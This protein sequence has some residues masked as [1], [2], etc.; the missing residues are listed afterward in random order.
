MTRGVI[1]VATGEKY[2]AEAIFSAASVKAIHPDLPITLFTDAETK[3]GLFDKILPADPLQ[4]PYL[5]KLVCMSKVLYDK[6]LYLDTDTYV[7][8][9]LEGMFSILERFDWG[10]TIA[11]AR[12]DRGDLKLLGDILTPI[13]ACFPQPNTGVIVFRH[14]QHMEKFF[15]LWEE[16]FRYY[17]DQANKRGEKRVNDQTPC[18]EALYQSNLRISALSPEYNCR[19]QYPGQLHGSVHIVHSHCLDIKLGASTVNKLSGMR[20]HWVSNGRLYV[21]SRDGLLVSNRLWALGSTNWGRGL[22]KTVQFWRSIA[23]M[24]QRR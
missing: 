24:I 16:R 3:P 17:L 8:G 2:V 18:R 5:T 23:N 20:V 15:N 12:T 19:L 21:R 22:Q 7:C 10:T 1:Y 4:T 14:S 13:P 11:P 6:T 9:D